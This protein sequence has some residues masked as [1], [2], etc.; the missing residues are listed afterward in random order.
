MSA[1]SGTARI[2]NSGNGTDYTNRT[3]PARPT[4]SPQPDHRA[5]G[6]VTSRTP[7]APLRG[8]D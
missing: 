4:R 8:R 2:G 1:A 3:A 5:P 6:P 7:S